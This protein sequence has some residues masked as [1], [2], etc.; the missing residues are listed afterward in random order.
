M[1]I[2]NSSKLVIGVAA[3]VAL[4][5]IGCCTFLVAISKMATADFEQ[6]VIIILSGF[7]FGAAVGITG[8]V[9]QQTNGAKETTTTTVPPSVSTPVTVT[10]VKE[11]PSPT[12]GG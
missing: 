11:H 1:T 4:S 3:V 6:L 9:I 5:V 8:H 10:T 7:G 12:T 2:S